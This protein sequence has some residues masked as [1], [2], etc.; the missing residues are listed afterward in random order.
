MRDVKPHTLSAQQHAL[1]VPEPQFTSH[2]LGEE[3]S[4]LAMQHGQ[5][6]HS[7]R[8]PQRRKREA[9]PVLAACLMHIKYLDS[10]QANSI[11]INSF[12]FINTITL[13]AILLHNA[14]EDPGT[15]ERLSIQ[16]GAGQRSQG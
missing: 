12:S 6:V 1:L 5:V 13:V 8:Q 4:V 9:T 7:K 3:E 16:D 11:A 2:P 10:N 15:C 14:S